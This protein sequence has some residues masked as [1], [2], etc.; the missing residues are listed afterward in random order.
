MYSTSSRYS[1]ELFHNCFVPYAAADHLSRLLIS[2]FD[3][4]PTYFDSEMAL[5]KADFID[6]PPALLMW[7]YA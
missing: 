6:C 5:N 3:I 1:P 2:T 4:K 7:I